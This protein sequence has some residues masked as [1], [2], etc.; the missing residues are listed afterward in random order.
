MT[1]R[2]QDMLYVLYISVP[3]RLER[4]IKAGKAYEVLDTAKS[5]TVITTQSRNNSTDDIDS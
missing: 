5:A 4:C 3:G 2:L 1:V